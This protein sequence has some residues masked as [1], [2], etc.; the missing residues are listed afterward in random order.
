VPVKLEHL[1][2]PTDADWN[3]L[4]KIHQDTAI[5]GLTLS[6]TDMK[7]WLAADRWIIAG[8]FNDRVVGACLAER[9]KN[10]VYLSQAGVRSITQGRGVMHQMI[11]FIQQW[12]EQNT[13][14]LIIDLTDTNMNDALKEAL[15]TRG[16]T[17]KEDLLTYNAD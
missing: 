9:K 10:Q 16:F 5:S 2:T 6:K 7:G 14:T 3:D 12:A 13:L 15:I 1:T 4:S 8:R 17:S 11:H